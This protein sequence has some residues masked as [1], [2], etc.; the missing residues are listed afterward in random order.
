MNILQQN[1]FWFSL[2]I[3]YPMLFIWQG[4]DMTDAG[5]SFSYYD[6][7]FTNNISHG[8]LRWL[9]NLIGALWNRYLG[10]LGYLGFKIAF[11]LV[12]YVNIFIV[13]LLLKEFD[14]KNILI[15]S[16]FLSEIF[17]IK[18]G[19]YWINY[20]ILTSLFYL[21]TIFFMFKGYKSEKLIY[22]ALAGVISGL[23]IFVRFPN[24]L[25]ILYVLT[26][27]YIGYQYKKSILKSSFSFIIGFLVG[28]GMMFILLSNMNELELYLSSVKQIFLFPREGYSSS[29]LVKL[30]INDHGAVFIITTFFFFFLKYF[31]KYILRFNSIIQLATIFIIALS[32]LYILN[33]FSLWKWLYSGIFYLSILIIF[34]DKN[35]KSDFKIL[36][37]FSFLFIVLAPLGSG[38]GIFNARF[39]MW[40]IMPLVMIYFSNTNVLKIGNKVFLDSGALEWSKKLFVIV[41]LF[42]SI[43]TKYHYTYRDSN[44][45]FEMLYPIHFKKLNY[46][47]TTKQRAKLVED[48]LLAL[49]KYSKN[50]KLFAYEKI[51][52]LYYLLDKTSYLSH[53]WAV[54]HMNPK[55]FNKEF[56]SFAKNNMPIMAVSKYSVSTFDWPYDKKLLSNKYN[57]KLNRKVVKDF[58]KNNNYKLIWQNEYFEIW[59]K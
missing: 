35:I 4:F 21:I 22:F 8:Y 33:I 14:K 37:I 47:Y 49:E 58:M 18:N 27:V 54:D 36:S 55:Q 24:I 40:L 39:G 12:V 53:P 48:F 44:D 41:T 46:I 59:D 17:I 9:T 20:N 50:R 7:F 45:R 19:G 51:T 29:S 11:V 2:I 28:I 15:F 56:L 10:W 38:N 3:I 32:S 30:F 31:T 57:S 6:S 5:F 23:N 42:F 16:L 34:F 43:V 26:I 25:N 1:K 52:I 13:W